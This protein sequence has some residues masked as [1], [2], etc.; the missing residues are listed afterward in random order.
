MTIVL[1][2]DN[3]AIIA[4]VSI[5]HIVQ[6]GCTCSFL[7]DTALFRILK[8]ILKNEFLNTSEDIFTVFRS[9][10]KYF[11]DMIKSTPYVPETFQVYS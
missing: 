3:A 7:V 6:D 9:I 1:I 4:T 8:E 2:V 11:V 10:I 5:V